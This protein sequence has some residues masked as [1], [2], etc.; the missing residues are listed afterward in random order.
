MGNPFKQWLDSDI[1]DLIREHPLAMMLSCEASGVSMTPLPMLPDTDGA[2]RL[3]R[4]V[5]H[6]ALRNPQ[7]EVL[8]RHSR[9]HF[10]FQGP[11]GYISPRIAGDR[12]WGPTWNYAVLQVEADVRLT[13]EKDNE[14]LLRLASVLEHGQA[15]AWRVEELG[16]RYSQLARRIVSFEADVRS[17]DATFKLGQDERPEIFDSIVEGLEST[18]LRT[19]MLRFA[20]R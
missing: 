9:V 4:L 6:I 1:V 14:A 16:E 12:S 13:P 7:V 11:Q 18:A 15:E 8:R 19:W 10:L 20:G 2:G 5:G 17:V 3:V